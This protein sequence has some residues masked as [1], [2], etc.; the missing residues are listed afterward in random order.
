M[1]RQAGTFFGA[2]GIYPTIPNDLSWAA[3][4]VEGSY[5]RGVLLGIVVG[6][7]NI[8][9]RYPQ[10]TRNCKLT[11]FPV[12]IVSSNIY[13]QSEKPR[14]R[15]GHSVVLAYLILF[16]FCGTLFIR[17]KLARENKKRRNGER[18]YLLEGKTEDEIVVAGDKRPDFMYTL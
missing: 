6:A 8:N 1:L 7:G 4:N 18:D 11:A 5:K 12:G 16:Q 17:T 15:T 3:N 9:G 14:Y 2:M 13:I 10:M